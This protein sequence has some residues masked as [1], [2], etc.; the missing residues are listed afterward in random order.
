MCCRSRFGKEY[1]PKDHVIYDTRL[2][3]RWNRDPKPNLSLS[4]FVTFANNPIWFND[5]LGDIVKYSSF[6]DRFKV[7]L[8]RISSKEFNKSFKE[9]KVSE[10]TYIFKGSKR[11]LEDATNTD[12]IKKRLDGYITTDG[13]NILINYLFD[14]RQPEAGSGKL[15]SLFHET[16]HGVQFE[17]GELGFLH[18]A[19]DWKFLSYDLGDEMKAMQAG[20]K[21]PGTIYEFPNG[22]NTFQGDMSTIGTDLHNPVTFMQNAKTLLYYY[23]N[24]P[25]EIYHSLDQV[26][27]NN[28]SKHRLQN[29]RFYLRPYS[30]R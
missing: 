11:D 27:I 9:L 24:Q 2:G 14:S 26:E 30:P 29:D 4:E 17:H 19:T 20:S 12:D 13:K 3:R 5:P 18:A 10:E 8:G 23:R 25:D 15:T 1:S 6:K 7:A 16:E 22:K 21:A 28:K